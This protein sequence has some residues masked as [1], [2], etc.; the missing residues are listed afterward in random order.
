MSSKR[1]F[2]LEDKQQ[3]DKL[4]YYLDQFGIDRSEMFE[5]VTEKIVPKDPLSMTDEDYAKWQR[6]IVG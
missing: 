1:L 4:I 3:V 5:K 6:Y 2:R